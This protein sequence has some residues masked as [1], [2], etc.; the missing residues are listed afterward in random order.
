MV[1][2][3]LLELR[4]IGLV[5]AHKNLLSSLSAPAGCALTGP[6]LT[7]RLG[8]SVLI[9]A[10]LTGAMAP[11]HGQSNSGYDPRSWSYDQARNVL[12]S[13]SDPD[14]APGGGM[15][16]AWS[17]IPRE[18]VDFGE[19]QPKGSIVINTTE[20]RLYYILGDGKALRYAVGVG[21]EG[22]AWSGRDTISSKKDWPEWR[23][24]AEMRSREALKGHF[25]PAR[26]SGGPNNPLGARALYI[27]NT[28]YR[29]HGTNEPW[30]VGQANSS[31]CI[32]M[33]NEDVID[34]YDRVKIGAQIIVRH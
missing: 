13:P 32:R 12:V 11:A 30:T 2:S 28:L 34:L 14:Q 5:A 9:A 18:I 8:K 22:L 1:A 19:A 33:T 6:R 15:P 25:L 21:K 26:V 10:T 20:R 24:P 27:G 3:F 17:A 16:T 23:P 29:V 7:R 31:G 4:G